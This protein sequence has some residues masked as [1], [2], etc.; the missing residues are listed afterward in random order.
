MNEFEKQLASQPVKSIPAEWR[1]QILG[2]ARAQAGREIPAARVQPL[3]WLRDL[4][5]P[6]PQAWGALAAV[7]I[8]VAVFHFI[9][10]GAA[11]ASGETMARTKVISVA[12]ERRELAELLDPQTKE[13]SPANRPRSNRAVQG[14]FV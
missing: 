3:S 6:G 12:E 9:T 11:R 2:A 8:V 14:R 5:W 7:W 1:A 13:R 4:L 10:P